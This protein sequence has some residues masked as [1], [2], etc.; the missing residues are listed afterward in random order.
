MVNNGFREDTGS[1]FSVKRLSSHFADTFPSYDQFNT[2]CVIDE[3][4]YTPHSVSF[5]PKETLTS[6][7]IM[8]DSKNVIVPI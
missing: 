5:V 8:V 2:P 3:R 1:E 6:S 7:G 4:T